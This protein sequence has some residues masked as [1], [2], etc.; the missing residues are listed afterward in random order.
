[1]QALLLGTGDRRGPRG[2]AQWY[3]THPEK[4]AVRGVGYKVERNRI[5]SVDGNASLFNK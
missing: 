1:M 5:A 2:I 3:Y 4:N